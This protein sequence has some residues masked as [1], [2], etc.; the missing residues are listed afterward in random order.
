MNKCSL[1]PFNESK[2]NYDNP[3]I[4]LE[5]FSYLRRKYENQELQ[6]GSKDIQFLNK[7]Y[8]SLTE[9]EYEKKV[10]EVIELITEYKS[11][12]KEVIPVKIIIQ[13]KIN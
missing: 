9:S 2:E 12:P 7:Y 11:Q 10:G 5:F 13:A 4:P 3:T 6:I 1:N 8:D